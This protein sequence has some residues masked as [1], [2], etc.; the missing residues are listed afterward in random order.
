MKLCVCVCVDILSFNNTGFPGESKKFS[1]KYYQ[2]RINCY[3]SDI[4]DIHFCVR[5]H[6]WR[7]TSLNTQTCKIACT[8]G[9]FIVYKHNIFAIFS[10]ITIWKHY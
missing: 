10:I 4:K 5:D 8:Q 3:S 7:P 2:C 1:K 9:S 6:G